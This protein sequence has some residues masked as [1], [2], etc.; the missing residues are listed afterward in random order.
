ML[1]LIEYSEEELLLLVNIEETEANQLDVF[2]TGL[3]SAI[4]PHSI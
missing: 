4:S 1:D 3:K 2:K